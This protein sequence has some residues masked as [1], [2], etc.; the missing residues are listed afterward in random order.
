[1]ERERNDSELSFKSDHRNKEKLSFTE[2]LLKKFL[3]ENTNFHNS[4][5]FKY[6]SIY[7]TRKEKKL[8]DL[9]IYE[10]DMY[11]SNEEIYGVMSLF[12]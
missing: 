1:M 8:T 4:F 10:E 7:L 5:P 3:P 12:P 11:L 2:K 6:F 9:D